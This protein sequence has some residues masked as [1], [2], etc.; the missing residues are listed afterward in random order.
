[1]DVCANKVARYKMSEPLNTTSADLYQFPYQDPALAAEIRIDNLISL[2]TTEEKVMCLSTNPSI[3]RL[4]I[5]GSGHV[6]GLHGLALGGP[7]SWG[8]DY[9]ITT[10]TFPQAIGMAST[11]DPG[12]RRKDGSGRSL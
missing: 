6:E 4:Q 5:R 7:G 9:P 8:K 12:N 10:T 3:P 2:L 11:W 1:M